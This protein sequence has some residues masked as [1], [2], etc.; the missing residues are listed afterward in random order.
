MSFQLQE[1]L[2][3]IAA[4][5]EANAA[6]KKENEEKNTNHKVIEDKTFDL[7]EKMTRNMYGDVSMGRANIQEA[8]TT[9]D[10]IKLI[11]KVIE[12]KLREAA[13]P[14]YLGTNFFETIHVDGSGSAVY[15]IPV[16]G[17]LYAHEVGEGQRY[18]EETFDMNTVE[19]AEIE[20]RVKK[21]GVK[22]SITEEAIADSSWDI[23]GINVRKMGKAM[24]RYKEEQIFNTFS[25]GCHTVFDN[26]LRSQDPS[27]GTTGR[28]KNGEFNDT[29]SV[30]DFLDA[31]MALMAKGYNPSD[32]IFHPLTWV[33]FARNSM[34]GN[35]LTFGALGGNNVSP[36]GTIQGTN[37][38]FGLQNNGNG[39]KLI[40]RPEDVQNRL[41]VPMNINFSPFV[42]FN[43]EN[44]TFDMYIIDRSEVG[45][46][47][48]REGL[49]T[50]N[51]SEPEKDIRM[52]KAKE[53]YGI[54]LLNN[55]QA[56]NVVKGI[57]VAP[58]YPLAPEVRVKTE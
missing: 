44:K 19:N 54:G 13:E 55:G 46:I 48:E 17:E 27:L 22:V 18:K 40:M 15:V 30:E 58:S 52:L 16:V 21:I 45:V 31:T 33:I 56:I 4:L 38:P 32:A 2:N 6:A 24:A 28:D 36:W 39:Q 3:R 53:R 14:S 10:T 20:V 37:A 51:W 47:V 9:T 42:K 1:T 5:K 34:L 11:P 29:L 41:P 50:D 23:L 12:G 57:A 8:L 35:G 26:N 25:D 43:K 49:S 7:M